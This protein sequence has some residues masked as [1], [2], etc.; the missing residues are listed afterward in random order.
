MTFK[1]KRSLKVGDLVKIR[2]GESMHDNSPLTYKENCIGQTA[3]VDAICQS[4]W[5]GR[6]DGPFYYYLR[7]LRETASEP[8]SKLSCSY[9]V[10]KR[11]ELIYIAGQEPN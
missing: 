2:C 3:R 8:S 1:P 9:W 5:D 7:R 10:W 11:N 4:G 6:R